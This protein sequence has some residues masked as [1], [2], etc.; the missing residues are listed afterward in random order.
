MLCPDAIGCRQTGFPLSG[1]PAVALDRAVSDGAACPKVVRT[2]NR[3]LPLT[4]RSGNGRATAVDLFAG[5]GGWT[6]GA[7]AA[8]IRVLWAGNHWRSA[9]DWHALNHPDTAHVCQ[10]LH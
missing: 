8:G 5:L 10:D 7:H 9:C 2:D 3:T 6:A 4:S 1:H